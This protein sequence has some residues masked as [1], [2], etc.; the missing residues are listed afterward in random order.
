MEDDRKPKASPRAVTAFHFAVGEREGGGLLLLHRGRRWR[1]LQEN[2]THLPITPRP[3]LN[4]WPLRLIAE[5]KPS[6]CCKSRLG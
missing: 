1:T 6:K 4:L 3:K 2:R 5:A